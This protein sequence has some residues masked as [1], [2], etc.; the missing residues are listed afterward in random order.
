V[1]IFLIIPYLLLVKDHPSLW[2][3]VDAAWAGMALCCPENRTQLY[4]EEI[5]TFANS[6]CTNFHKV[7]EC[8]Y[9][10]TILENNGMDSGDL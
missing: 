10:R 6:F 3:H 9:I 2:V 7:C 1:S 4:L 8:T 5:N